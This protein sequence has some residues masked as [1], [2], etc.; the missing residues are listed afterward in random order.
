MSPNVLLLE[1]DTSFPVD[2]DG[3]YGKL[4][5]KI[6]DEVNPEYEFFRKRGSIG[7]P[8]V[9]IQQPQTHALWREFKM[10]KGSAEV[11]FLAQIRKVAG[12]IA[13]FIST[14]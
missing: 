11:G 5:E 10:H 6:L 9:L 13:D 7:E 3:K 4:M 2:K 1:P 12:L 14:K 8:L